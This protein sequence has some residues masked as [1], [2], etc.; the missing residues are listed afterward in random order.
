MA[1]ARALFQSSDLYFAELLCAADDPEWGED[2]L[3]T[4]P[5]VALPASPVWQAHDGAA[6]T[7]MNANHAVF[8]H[9]GS[10][11]RRERFR[12]G[13][14]R[15]VFFFPADSLVREIAAELDPAAADTGTYRFPV[16]TAP[17]DATTFALS[18]R[19]AGELSSGRAN[20]LPVRE[21]LYA[22]LRSAVVSGYR[23]LGPRRVVRPTTARARS[24]IVEEAKELITRRVA[25]RVRLDDLSR[26]LHVS[27]YHLA[28]IFRTTTGY[29]LHAYQ[30]HLRL[31]E[32]LDRLERGSA[33]EVGELGIH[34]GFSSHSHFTASFHKT[35]GVRPS[36][37]KRNSLSTSA[38]ELGRFLT[39]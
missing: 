35:L 23:H 31:R 21:G 12:G 28:R 30:T 10:Q 32:G 15:C 17:L 27:A 19:L 5:I 38:G 11:Y 18:R 1:I 8:H 34:L 13:G 3:V 4:R 24:E 25:D 22:V 26:E 39:A 29:S 14:Y 7:L 37:V 36:E 16:R 33:K 20:G 2:N 9:A 6:P